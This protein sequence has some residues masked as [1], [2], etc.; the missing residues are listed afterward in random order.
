MSAFSALSTKL[1]PSQVAKR[2]DQMTQKYSVRA[3]TC[4]WPLAVFYEILDLAA[5]NASILFQK[6]TNDKMSQ[7]TF[8]LRRANELLSGHM[9]A[10]P[11]PLVREPG[12]RQEQQ[13]EMRRQCQL[14]RYSKKNKTKDTCDKCHKVICWSCTWKVILN[15]STRGSE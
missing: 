12:P 11:R 1:L 3:P 5:I 7:K 13:M 10:K 2:L 9:Q 15:Q 14:P 8:I 4:R 6:C